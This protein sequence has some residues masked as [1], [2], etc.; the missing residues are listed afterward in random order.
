MIASPFNKASF[1]VMFAL[2]GHLHLE[3]EVV[4]GLGA[5]HCTFYILFAIMFCSSEV[6]LTL[7][8][9]VGALTTSLSARNI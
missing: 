1:F 3:R 2:S 9:A 7:P 6:A 4:A 5:E 8:L